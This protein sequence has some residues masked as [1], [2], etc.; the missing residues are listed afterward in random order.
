[1]DIGYIYMFVNKINNKKYIGQTW[2]YKKRIREHYNGWGYAKLLKYALNKYGKENLEVQILFEGK[3]DQET[4][5][6]K[7]INFI[8]AFDSLQPNGY[9]L[10]SGGAHGKHSE[11][12]KILIGSYHKNKIVSL[13]TRK[14]LSESNK[15]KIVSEETK[16]KISSGHQLASKN[17]DKPIYIFNCL[18]HELIIKFQN[19]FYLKEQIEI[20]PGRI[21]GSISAGSKFLY[22]NAQCYASY[23]QEPNNKNYTFGTPV[24]I[25]TELGE[26]FYYE[27]ITSAQNDLNL[28]RG[29]IDSLVRNLVKQ[30]KYIKDGEIIKFTAKYFSLNNL[31]N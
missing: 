25:T 5:D 29:I 6:K 1:M 26:I 20:P 17:K 11:L 24:E 15:N 27:S 3:I 30:S 19:S 13:E 14:K 28:N 10:A 31:K 16:E 21:F 7:E 23:I 12:T 8:T 22:K 4:L 2:N 9:N 18:T